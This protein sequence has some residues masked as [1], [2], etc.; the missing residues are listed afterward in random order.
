MRDDQLLNKYGDFLF[1][2]NKGLGDLK[3]VWSISEPIIIDLLDDF[4]ANLRQQGELNAIL[5]G[6]AKSLENLKSAQLS[7]WA[8]VLGGKLGDDF[9]QSAK[10]VG[11]VH[12]R[13]G[14][15]Q[16][17]YLA[18]YAWVL[19][20]LIPK[21]ANKSRFGFKSK[22][23]G[24]LG[25]IVARIFLD[26]IMSTAAYEEKVIDSMLN[27]SNK[28]NNT[29]SLRS[30]A[31][32]V[33]QVNATSFHLARLVGNAREVRL[34]SQTISSAASQLVASVEQIA[35][36]SESAANEANES[37]QTAQDGH[38]AIA[39][40]TTAIGKMLDA[41]NETNEGIEELS[42]AS[43]QIG[44]ILS[45]IEDIA[46]QTNLLA[47][48]AT[49]EA[50]RAGEAGKGFAVVASEVKGLAS[51]TSKSTEDIARRIE[52][53]SSGMDKIRRTM[54]H[55]QSA[56]GEGETAVASARETMDMIS[57]QVGG[58]YEKMLD[59]SNILQQQKGA[60]N[61]IAHSITSVADLSIQ[62]EDLI[63]EMSTSFQSTND[64]FSSN[65][66][67]WFQEG[68][69]QALCEMAKIDHVLFKKR[70]IDTIM[71]RDNWKPNEVPDHHS[72]RLGK[73]YDK[74]DKPGL[75]NHPAYKA[76]VGPHKIV[77]DAGKQALTL[78]NAGDFNGAIIEVER[79]N[80]ASHDVVRLLADLST[81]LDTESIT[82]LREYERL[83]TSIHAKL[84][85]DSQTDLD[86]TI[87]DISS[88]GV[89]IKGVA[90][91][92]GSSVSISV[93]ND[94]PRDG[95]AKWTA[96]DRAGILFSEEAAKPA[97]KK[98]G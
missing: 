88:E 89:G 9:Q 49:I 97:Q 57:G 78:Y 96:G 32:T 17:W 43:T 68:S 6:S 62:N 20:R 59:I 39:E 79:M 7:H 56:V 18:S 60:A 92:A 47:L 4:Y 1:D 28:A 2:G 30:L 44:Q 84:N 65:A 66:K 75:V 82:D 61:E 31:D 74:L 48:N 52:A 11:A 76:L 53:L 58:V 29:N 85:S 8:M 41:V 22:G 95:V 64:Q 19:M 10:T 94:G 72:C 42:E 46:N 13:I 77:H 54:S 14:L 55:S 83:K 86:V 98:A 80:E 71:E 93:G 33:V 37:N 63:G 3:G 5:D 21:L 40:A 16:G 70:I 38:N 45:D 90:L 34:G 73:W 51:Q 87:E 12:E 25:H 23:N 15:N 69:D 50:A 26:M 24:Q 81:S 67:D 91:D 36:N 35:V 27:H